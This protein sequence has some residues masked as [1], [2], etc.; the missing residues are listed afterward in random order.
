MD[1]HPRMGDPIE[2]LAKALATRLQ[3]GNIRRWRGS[4]V[5]TVISVTAP[6]GFRLDVWEDPA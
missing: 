1:G 3:P 2:R 5:Q 6:S 4:A